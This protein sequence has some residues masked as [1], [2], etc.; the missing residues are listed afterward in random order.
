MYTNLLLTFSE[1]QKS[2]LTST[3]N[4]MQ[5]HQKQLP[6]VSSLVCKILQ[7]FVVALPH[8]PAHRKAIIFQNLMSII[9]LNDY[10]WITLIQ[11][12][13]H[14]L[15]QSQDLLEFKTNLEEFTNKQKELLA[16]GA[17]PTA[18]TTSDESMSVD[19]AAAKEKK[20][21]STLMQ[22][23]EAMIALHVQFQP[24]DVIQ[25]AIYLTTF[26]NKYLTKLFQSR[27]TIIQ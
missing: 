5:R 18:A 22:C 10:L 26:L 14:Y 17:A 23:M 13:D 6:Y 15:V 4:T 11:A 19:V 27:Y 24:S 1:S 3:V 2:R 12:L 20:L 9:G 25:S 16:N 7:S 21:R 8:I